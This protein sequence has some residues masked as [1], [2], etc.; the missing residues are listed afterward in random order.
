MNPPGRSS[1]ELYFRLLAYVK[2][3]WRVF[4]GALAC[5][6]FGALLEPVFPWVV[7]ELLDGSFVEQT[8]RA[9]WF[10]PAFIVGLFFLRGLFS[11]G[12]DYGFAWLS[13][14]IIL[15]LR[16][17]M[18]R[19]LVTLPTAFFNNQ[20]SGAL[21]SKA[22]YDVT[23]VTAAATSVITTAV[24]DTLT[25]VGLLGY[26]IWTNWRLT[27]IIVV[28]F[29]GIAFIVRR[30]SHR[31]RSASRAAQ[32][33]M[34]SISHTLQE[35]I[36]AQ[37]VV[38]IFGGQEYERARFGDAAKSQ[39]RANMR[40]AIASAAVTPLVQLLVACGLS[41]IIVLALREA[42]AGRM[43]PGG[44]VSFI[45]AM[46]MLLPPIKRIT[47][48]NAALQRGLAA[49]ESVFELVDEKGEDDKGSVKLSRAKG[50]IRFEHVDFAYPKTDRKVLHDIDLSIA[51]G[52]TIAL[53]GASG[54][55]KST[56]AHLL[57]RFYHLERGR[58]LLDG[59]NVEDI[60]LSSLRRQIAL[61]SQDVVLFNDTVA[62]NIAYG[63]LRDVGRDKIVAAAQAA[64]AMEFI[65]SLPQGLDT[66]VGQNGAK[67]SGGQR[68]RL[69]IARALLKDAP[70]LILDEAT[71]ALDSESERHVQ[72]AL[73]ELMRNRT[74]LV[75]AHRL[76]TIE[77]ATRIVVMDRGRIVEVG[78]HAELLAAGG[79]YATLYRTQ[80][81]LPQETA[82]TPAL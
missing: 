81:L 30:F 62:A 13:N 52:E 48:M 59:H 60:S 21:V 66:L 24:R 33:A 77:R 11:Y 74:T 27:L 51:S 1:R 25:I 14:Q 45:G 79:Y 75:I 22:A 15:D 12:S 61:V 10:Y 76:S 3:H 54:S 7:K 58:I 72:A 23:G 43:S 69:A 31:I 35:T 44:F 36:E 16:D 39:H 41:I 46:L 57:P 20:A 71:S 47:Q 82:E 18:F 34:G 70:V 32:K 28:L 67:L 26:M 78:S 68:Q 56:M 6:A 37:K 9:W 17:A 49:A 64:H 73:D 2:P 55:G 8:P 4:A 38:K 42:T 19:R 65:E 29:P 40:L 63:V 80:M 53:V 5:M 50:S